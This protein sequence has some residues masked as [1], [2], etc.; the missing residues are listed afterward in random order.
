M[1]DETLGHATASGTNFVELLRSKGI[2]AGIKVDK[3]I[4]PMMGTNAE[5]AT[6]GLDGLGARCAA[7]Y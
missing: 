3:G 4:V 1:F 7:Y 6:Q 5:T 2:Y